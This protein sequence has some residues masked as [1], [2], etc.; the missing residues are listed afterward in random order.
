MAFGKQAAV[1]RR[2]IVHGGR[3]GILRS[4]A[5]VWSE[6][7]EAMQR[8]GCGDGTMRLG[9][10]AEVAAAM[11]I[12]E[13]SIINVGCFHPFSRNAVHLGRRNVHRRRHFVRIRPENLARAAVIPYAS[14]AALHAPLGDP[15]CEMRLQA[16]HSCLLSP[17]GQD[18]AEA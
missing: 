6:N 13:D 3:K 15:H 8:E 11:Q 10:T 14:Q 12:Q 2:G 4:E 1:A 16:G 5:I 18:S 7:A 9:G 17:W